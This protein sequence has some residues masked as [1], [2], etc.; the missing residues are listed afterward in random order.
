MNDTVQDVEKIK[1][2]IEYY[3]NLIQN[4]ALED[5]RLS[6]SKMLLDLMNLK[7]KYLGVEKEEKKSKITEIEVRRRLKEAGV[8]L[9][10]VS[11]P[12]RQNKDSLNQD[13]E[14]IENDTW[15]AMGMTRHNSEFK[16]SAGGRMMPIENMPVMRGKSTDGK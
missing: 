1:W 15:G 13:V 5:A 7:F 16:E 4:C 2:M 8:Q 3:F 9:T 10:E 14:E 11:A 6:A 12:L